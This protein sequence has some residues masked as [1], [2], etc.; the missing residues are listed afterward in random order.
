MLRKRGKDARLQ[1]LG[2]F[3]QGL[4]ASQVMDEALWLSADTRWPAHVCCS[5]VFAHRC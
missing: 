1:G 3:L 4:S 2:A 5:L